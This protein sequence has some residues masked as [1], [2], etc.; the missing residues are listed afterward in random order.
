MDNNAFS[1]YKELPSWAKGVVAIGGIG[2]VFYIGYTLIRRI[3][4]QAETIKM[5]ETVVTQETELKD[6]LDT[7]MKLTYGESQYKGWANQLAVEFAGC[8][9]FNASFG[10][11]INIIYKLRNDA[12]FLKLCTSYDIRTYDQCGCCSDFK[13]NLYEAV[14]DEFNNDDI[15]KLNKALTGQKITY[16]F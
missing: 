10:I 16:Q 9:P 3:K 4:S 14:K 5:R 7:G 2:I 12:D 1:Y 6:K 8:D 15:I 13:G 11:L